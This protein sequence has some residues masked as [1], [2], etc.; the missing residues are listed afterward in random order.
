MSWQSRPEG[1][2]IAASQAPDDQLQVHVYATIYNSHCYRKE[3]LRLSQ[4]TPNR[5]ETEYAMDFDRITKPYINEDEMEGKQ[6]L[7]RSGS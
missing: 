6:V 4:H 3:T 5:N 7:N 1:I 2:Q